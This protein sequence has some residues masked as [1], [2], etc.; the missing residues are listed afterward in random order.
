[1]FI[2]HSA[3]IF[4]FIYLILVE[5]FL[6]LAICSKNVVKRIAIDPTDVAIKFGYRLKCSS[7]RS[8]ASL[9]SIV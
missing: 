1:M 6:T 2:C 3:S 9:G 8:T 4:L 5:R 7:E